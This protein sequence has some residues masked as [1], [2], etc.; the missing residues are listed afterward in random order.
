MVMRKACSASTA[1]VAVLAVVLTG[2]AAAGTA[3]A[4]T[5]TDETHVIELVN[6][7]RSQKGVQTLQR[8]DALVKMAREQAARMAAKGT[9]FHNPDLGPQATLLGLHWLRLG[10]NVGMGWNVDVIEDA[11]LKSPHHYENIVRPAYNS[12]GVGVV[13]AAERV[14]VAQVFG[15]LE[16][17]AKVTLPAAPDSV[18]APLPPAR[19]T[20]PAPPP[21]PP[22]AAPVSTPIPALPARHPWPNALTGGVVSQEPVP[23]RAS[24]QHVSDRPANGSFLARLLDRLFPG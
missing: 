20:V 3:R 8:N 15:Q 12:I 14:F 10:E 18:S 7:T 22:L 11:I 17:A 19:T 5:A 23:I 21:P 1:L 6:G 4:S 24:D 9:I 2:L 13:Y 16:Q